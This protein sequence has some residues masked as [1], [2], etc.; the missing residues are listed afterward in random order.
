[1]VESFL[2]HYYLWIKALHV[3]FIICW[4]AGLLY[5][6]RLFVYHT[7]APIGSEM[8]STFQVMERKLYK[9][10]MNPSMMGTWLCGL[11]LFFILRENIGIWF[12]IKATLVI[13]LTV[14]HL[15]MKRY[16]LN[17]AVGRNDKSAKFFRCFNEIPA[18]IMIV[19]VFLVILQPF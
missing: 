6:P 19:V 15:M 1:M 7:A 8:D 2:A 13:I 16:I 14:M 4:M 18:V 5:L 17:F 12:H 10:I 9:I 11:L 3:V